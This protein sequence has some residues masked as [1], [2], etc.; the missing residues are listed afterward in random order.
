MSYISLAIKSRHISRAPVQ[1]VCAT[2]T[3]L[4]TCRDARLIRSVALILCHVIPPCNLI[5][6]NEPQRH[7]QTFL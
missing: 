5:V 4:C 6:L 1:N 7:T 2:T 3:K